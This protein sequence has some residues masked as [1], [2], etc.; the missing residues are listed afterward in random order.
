MADDGWFEDLAAASDAEPERSPARLTSKVY[1]AVVARMAERAPLLDLKECRR[2]GGHLC[3][4][5]QALTLLP[6]ATGIGSMNPCR[7]C[8]ARA[9]GERMEHA[10]IFWP[11]C[12]YSEFHIKGSAVD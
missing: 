8:H 5:E 12:P 6:A 2:T 3:V 4:F 1:S 9:L 11:G 10:P 7:V